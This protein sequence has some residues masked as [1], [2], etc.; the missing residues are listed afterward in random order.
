VS[1]KA[2]AGMVAGILTMIAGILSQCPE[3]PPARTGTTS[4]DAGAP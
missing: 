3:D 2:L 4:V 1:K